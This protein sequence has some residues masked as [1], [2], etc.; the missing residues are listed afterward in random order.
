MPRQFET[1]DQIEDTLLDQIIRF[2]FARS[3]DAVEQPNEPLR[4]AKI[5]GEIKTSEAN[6]APEGERSAGNMRRFAR[7][8]INA[9]ATSKKVTQSAIAKAKPPMCWKSK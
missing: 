8:L 1:N 9:R 3:D 6:N 7:C 5:C 2:K 4:M